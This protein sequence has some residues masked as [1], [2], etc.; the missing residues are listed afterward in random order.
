MLVEQW[1]AIMRI[2]VSKIRTYGKYSLINSGGR[3]AKLELVEIEEM[4]NLDRTK[5]SFERRSETYKDDFDERLRK[6]MSGTSNR[7][8][9]REQR[10]RWNEPENRRSSRKNRQPR[11]NNVDFDRSERNSRGREYNAN[12]QGIIL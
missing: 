3:Y 8:F 9:V 5:K 2:Y 12:Y 11:K 7:K 4:M 10:E 6:H 1:N